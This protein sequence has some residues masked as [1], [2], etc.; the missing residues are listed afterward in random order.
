[1]DEMRKKEAESE[2]KRL[3]RKEELERRKAEEVR[4]QMD[5]M[6]REVC[7]NTHT[8]TVHA[9]IFMRMHK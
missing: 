9:Y 4:K 8:R 1:M 6:N 7:T 5:E 2:Q 3:Q